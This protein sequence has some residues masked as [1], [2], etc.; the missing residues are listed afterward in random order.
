MKDITKL[1]TKD[2][3]VVSTRYHN[4]SQS[5]SNVNNRRKSLKASRVFNQNFNL[6]DSL[7]NSRSTTESLRL[8]TGK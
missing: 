3:S 6:I 4:N 8:P 1:F 2:Y 7:F 5:N